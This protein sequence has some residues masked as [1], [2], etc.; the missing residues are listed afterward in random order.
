LGVAQLL[1]PRATALNQ[2]DQ[3]DHKKNAGND[4]D[5]RGV[6]HSKSP[7]HTY[8]QLLQCFPTS[9]SSTPDRMQPVLLDPRATA[10]NQNDQHDHKKNAGNDPDN[11]GVIHLASPPFFQ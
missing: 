4:P 2:N 7:F 10:L 5:N 6:I 3:H 9:P 11:R 1:D 8:Q